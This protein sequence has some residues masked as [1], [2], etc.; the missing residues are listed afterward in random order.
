MYVQ[1]PAALE[2][3]T[4][5]SAPKQFAVDPNMFTKDSEDNR[6]L[7]D[8]GTGLLSELVNDDDAN[9]Q[10]EA[11]TTMQK[12]DLDYTHLPTPSEPPPAMVDMT[13]VCCHCRLSVGSSSNQLLFTGAS[14]QTRLAQPCMHAG[15]CEG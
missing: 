1:E 14:Q 15:S 10:P 2:R 5:Q 8:A 13:K 11:V 9:H 4:E 12:S 3:P 6:A 7:L